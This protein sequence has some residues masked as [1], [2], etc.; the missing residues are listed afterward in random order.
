M[1]SPYSAVVEKV[2]ALLSDRKTR[3]V[4][5]K[6]DY[7]F[8]ESAIKFVMRWYP[9]IW[10]AGWKNT[11]TERL[12]LMCT[13]IKCVV[14]EGTIILKCILSRVGGFKFYSSGKG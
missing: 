7:Q 4:R 2:F 10:E 9:G 3:A 12:S 5:M 1:M 14:V 6:S 11:V 8:R 13:S